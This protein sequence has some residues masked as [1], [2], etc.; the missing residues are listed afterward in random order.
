MKTVV[1]LF[2]RYEDAELAVND[3]SSRGFGK[4]QISIAARESAI[5]E[6]VAGGKEQAVAESAGAGAVG[7][8]AVGAIGGLLIG[9]GAL[10]IPG[11]GPVIAAGTLATTLGA[12]VAG[13]GIGA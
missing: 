2:D 10:V 6:R 3:L 7:G 9:L 8:T 12:T 11:I 5:R 4:D 13:A 1:G